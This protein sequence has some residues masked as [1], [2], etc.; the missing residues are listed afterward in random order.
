MRRRRGPGSP[1]PSVSSSSR[2]AAASARG[3]GTSIPAAAAG[4]T[5]PP[6]PTTKVPR[7]AGPPAQPLAAGGGGWDARRPPRPGVGVLGTA[8]GSVVV[9]GRG[10]EAWAAGAESGQR[11]SRARAPPLAEAAWVLAAW[12]GRGGERPPAGRCGGAGR[13][14]AAAARLCTGRRSFGLGP[15]RALACPRS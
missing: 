10:C 13:G 11:A 8:G 3:A 7:G 9:G 1:W 4:G 12:E 6:R 5:G 14:G 2:A 15:P